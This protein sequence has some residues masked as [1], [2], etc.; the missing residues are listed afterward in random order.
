MN[1][2]CSKCSKQVSALGQYT[3]NHE[4]CQIKD[5][6]DSRSKHG[7][8]M[9]LEWWAKNDPTMWKALTTIW[10]DIG[11]PHKLPRLIIAG[12]PSQECMHPQK[13]AKTGMHTFTSKCVKE[14]LGVNCLTCKGPCVVE[15][16]IESTRTVTLFACM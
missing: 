6:I 2:Q 7:R 10:P 16:C 4:M 1:C 12:L 14:Q 3:A 9:R 15:L 8:R 11:Q 5:D 13:I